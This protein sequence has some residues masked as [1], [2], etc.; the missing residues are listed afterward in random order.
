MEA[1][2]FLIIMR[3]HYRLGSN[4][5]VPIA[6]VVVGEDRVYSLFLENLLLSAQGNDKDH[7][8]LVMDLDKRLGRVFLDLLKVFRFGLSE[9]LFRVRSL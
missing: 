6:K 8:V 5:W 9:Y 2:K 3:I 7:A 4:R 1:F